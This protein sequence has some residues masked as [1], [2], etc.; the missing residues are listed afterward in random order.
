MPASTKR[1]EERARAA[2]DNRRL[3]MIYY[4]RALGA[5]VALDAQVDLLQSLLNDA[6]DYESLPYL[7]QSM[8]VA[9]AAM[10][11]F[12]DHLCAATEQK[13]ALEDT[14]TA[15]DQGEALAYMTAGLQAS[16]EKAYHIAGLVVIDAATCRLYYLNT[17]LI[18]MAKVPRAIPMLKLFQD[19]SRAY[20]SL[21][22]ALEEHMDFCISLGAAYST[23][24]LDDDQMDKIEE[25]LDEVWR[26][27]A[28]QLVHATVKAQFFEFGQKFFEDMDAHAEAIR[29]LDE[30]E[31]W[32]RTPWEYVI[33]SEALLRDVEEVGVMEDG[34]STE[35]GRTISVDGT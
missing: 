4:P 10:E 26:Q 33:A 6:A 17:D 30:F 34:E 29:V 24:A 16:I 11:L 9:D 14:P 15:G 3:A 1:K 27:R 18:P 8:N 19:T 25:T 12:L 32:F 21:K 5:K 22:E 20:Q 31:E 35:S 7:Q 23:G 28:N 13:R 2:R